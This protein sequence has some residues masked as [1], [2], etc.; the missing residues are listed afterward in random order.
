MFIVHVFI[1]IITALCETSFSQ[2]EHT[3]LCRPIYLYYI[4]ILFVSVSSLQKLPYTPS[5]AYTSNETSSQI[6]L[7]TERPAAVPLR[8]QIYKENVGITRH[9]Y[10]S[11]PVEATGAP[12]IGSS[13]LFLVCIWFIIIIILDSKSISQSANICLNNL[14]SRRISISNSTLVV[15]S[16]IP[17]K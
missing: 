7:T 10:M 2:S 6:Y 1:I 9:A 15:D 8:L 5:E 4:L 14:N 17:Q 3:I 12:A 13:M 11:Q 16:T